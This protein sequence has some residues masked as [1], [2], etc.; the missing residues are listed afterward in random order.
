MIAA[1]I[2]DT[3]ITKGNNLCAGGAPG[4]SCCSE[5]FHA[6]EG[7]DPTTGTKCFYIYMYVYPSLCKLYK[8]WIYIYIDIYVFILLVVREV[9]VSYSRLGP[10]NRQGEIYICNY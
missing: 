4:A 3:D 6:T 7:W 8:N 5:G 2:I 10:N 1:I 9:G